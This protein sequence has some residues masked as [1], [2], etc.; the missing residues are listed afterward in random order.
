[1]CK[2]LSILEDKITRMRKIIPRKLGKLG[3]CMLMLTRGIWK[4]C[5]VSCCIAFPLFVSVVEYVGI[6]LLA[7]SSTKNCIYVKF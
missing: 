7:I 3:K 4:V 1:M 2:E 5:S 6:E